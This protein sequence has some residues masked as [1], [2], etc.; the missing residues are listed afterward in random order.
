MADAGAQSLNR[1]KTGITW[2]AQ[3]THRSQLT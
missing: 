1:K 2:N 3:V